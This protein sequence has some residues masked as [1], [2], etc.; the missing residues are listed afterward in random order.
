MKTIIIKTMTNVPFWLSS[1][2]LCGNSCTWPHDVR[3]HIRGTN[4]T[5]SAEQAKQGS[6][7][8]DHSVCRGSLM[9]TYDHFGSLVMSLIL[10]LIDWFMDLWFT[11]P[12]IPVSVFGIPYLSL[13]YHFPYNFV[14]CFFMNWLTI[15][16]MNWIIDG[17]IISYFI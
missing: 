8:F 16:L 4:E 3:L 5:K 14:F 11:F 12:Y 2:L 6:V 13:V 1:H 15:W 7:R 10:T 17:V 9:T